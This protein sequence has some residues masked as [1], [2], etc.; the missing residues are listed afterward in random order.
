MTLV[1]RILGALLNV[2]A[3]AAGEAAGLK[4]GA[5]GADSEFRLGTYER[6][7]QVAIA[8]SLSAGDVFYDVGANVGFF[9]LIA[10][11]KVGPQ[12][13]VYAFEPVPSNV[14]VITC[15]AQLNNFDKITVFQEAVGVAT[16]RA[17]LLLAH[18]IGGA[19][20]ASA[21]AP[22]DNPRMHRG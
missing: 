9:S 13:C 10:A 14:S 18:H 7:V 19:T 2:Q 12:G 20:L 16:G 11:R 3:I 8:A 5:Y 21:G 17:E 22:P 15:C 1:S 4:L 6:P